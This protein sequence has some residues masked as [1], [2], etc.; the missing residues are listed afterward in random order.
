MF[1]K[2]VAGLGFDERSCPRT[3]GF[4]IAEALKISFE[5]AF[6]ARDEAGKLCA[7]RSWEV[8]ALALRG[9]PGAAAAHL[10][11]HVLPHLGA[12]PETGR[13]RLTALAADLLSVLTAEAG[14][15]AAGERAR[16][17]GESSS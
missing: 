8:E 12:V 5:H 17:S 4:E 9:D 6:D 14:S 13:S 1:G 15:T 10:E 16:A 2:P 11:R 7:Y 3:R